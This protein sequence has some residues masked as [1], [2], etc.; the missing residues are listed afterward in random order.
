MILNSSLCA[1]TLGHCASPLQRWSTAA[2]SGNNWLWEFFS[3]SFVEDINGTGE[4]A[5]NP[6]PEHKTKWSWQRFIQRPSPQKKK[7]NAQNKHMASITF[8]GGE[9]SARCGKEK[10]PI[11]YKI[12]IMLLH[13]H[14]FLLRAYH[15]MQST[16]PCHRGSRGAL[17]QQWEEKTLVLFQDEKSLLRIDVDFCYFLWKLHEGEI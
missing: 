6:H 5:T 3:F 2:Q 14:K 11:K 15:S 1:G 10:Y 13:I 9:T 4:W 16:L 12:A 8:G 7:K 17:Q